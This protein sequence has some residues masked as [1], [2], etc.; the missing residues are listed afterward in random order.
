MAQQHQSSTHYVQ[1]PATLTEMDGWGIVLISSTLVGDGAAQCMRFQTAWVTTPELD[2]PIAGAFPLGIYQDNELYLRL[3]GPLQ[4]MLVAR[5][6]RELGQEYIWTPALTDH[7]AI[8]DQLDVLQEAYRRARA[9]G[10]SA[11]FDAL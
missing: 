9:L 5:Y 1:V 10:Y 8:T 7:R 6:G 4:P 11:L 3:P 2:Y